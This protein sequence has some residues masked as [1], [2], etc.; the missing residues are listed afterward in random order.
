MLRKEAGGKNRIQGV[1]TSLPK[2][3]N[4]EGFSGDIYRNKCVQKG[5]VCTYTIT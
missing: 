1:H 5:G 4:M 2:S 3:H